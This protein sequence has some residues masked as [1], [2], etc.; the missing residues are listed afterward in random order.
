[1]L[2]VQKLGGKVVLIQIIWLAFSN[3]TKG[4]LLVVV[5]EEQEEGWVVEQEPLEVELLGQGE[6]AWVVAWEVV[7]ELEWEELLE[8]ELQMEAW[9]VLLMEWVVGWEVLVAGW[10]V[11]VEQHRKVELAGEV[12]EWVGGQN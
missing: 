3:K 7:L 1:M 8:Q 11:L 2:L 4:H 10:E 6:V 9:A 12:W 5:L